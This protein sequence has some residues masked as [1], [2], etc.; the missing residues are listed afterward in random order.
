MN[1]YDPQSTEKKWQKIWQETSLYKTPTNPKN[2]YYGLVMFA[3]PS[4]NLHCGHWYPFTGGDILARFARMHGHDVLHTNGFDA[5]GLPAENAA[6]KHGKPADEWTDENIATMKNQYAAMGNMYDWDR[7]I[8]T[9]KPDYYKWTQWLFLQLLKADKAYQKKGLVNWCPH[10]HTTLA[11]EQVI[12]GVCERCETKVERKNLKQWYFKTTDYADKLIKGLDTIDWPDRIKD[13]QRNW[14]GRSEGTQINFTIDG[15]SDALTVF[16]T[17]PDTLFGVTFMVIAPEHPLV[18]VI[19]SD[20]QRPAVSQ[21]VNQAGKKTDVARMEEKDKTGVFT[22]TYAV[23]PA[24]NEQIPIWVADYVLMG[25]GTGAIM[26]VPAHDE[27]D[28]E[29]AHK[30]GLEIKQVIE[31]DVQAN[32][33]HTGAGVLINSGRFDG[34]EGDEAKN[35]ITDWLKESELGQTHTQY[36]LRDWLI[37]RQRYWGTPIPVIHCEGCGVVGVPE[38]DLPVVLPLNQK[39]DSTGRSPLLDDSFVNVQCPHCKSDAKRETDTMDTFVDSSWYY[40]RYPNPHYTQGPFDHE[41]IKQWLPVSTYIGGPEHA[42]M[43]LLYVRFIAHF[44]YENGHIPMAEPLPK[45]ICNGLI[46]GPDGNKMSKSK[47]NVVDPDDY[48]S[49]YGADSVRLYMM[50]MGPYDDGGPWDPQ[51][52]EGAHRFVNKVYDL[53]TAQY[54]TQ[55]LNT[56]IE[57]DLEAKLHKLIKK[58]SE[59]IGEAHFNTA[60]AAFMEFTN[61]LTKVRQAGSVSAD[62]WK[63]SITLLAVLLAPIT[64]HL[65]EEIWVTVGNTE[66]VHLQAWPKYDEDKVKDDV[67][68]IVIQVNGKLRGEFVATTGTDQAEL[69][70]LATALNQKENFT[71]DAETVKVIVVPNRLVNFVVK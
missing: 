50:F 5:F 70:K 25:Y 28:F 18:D 61:T 37:S 62:A 59:D 19:I 57:A 69:E 31:G 51:R 26:A 42:T 46:M 15:H 41:A 60:I 34:L 22:G 6:I 9:S 20:T 54:K 43:H 21:Y 2:P 35:E 12:H 33:V 48:V 66:S 32:T 3:Y 36:R 39:I 56:E 47:G 23:N 24:T 30:Y 64:P 29:F 7:V 49:K 38:T 63:Q 45:F 17:R 16:T 52:F 68:T 13:A 71:N 55:E 11:N 44:L 1:T 14:I 27:R 65:S 58:V 67:V 8:D 4:G 40:L 10:C 53:A